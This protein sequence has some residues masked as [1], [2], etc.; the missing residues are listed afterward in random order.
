[1]SVVHVAVAVI[2]RDR[3]HFFDR[4]ILISC[5]ADDVHQGGLWEFP[6]GKVERDETVVEALARELQEELGIEIDKSSSSLEPLI[7]IHHDYGDKQVFL[8]VWRVSEFNCEPHGKEGQPVQWVPLSRLHAF[9]F[10]AANQPIL[11]ACQLPRRY[12]ITPSY[13][14]LSEAKTDI[15]RLIDEGAAMILLRQPQLDSG[16]Y[17]KWADEL[18]PL[19]HEH[20]VK[21]L[22]SGAPCLLKHHEFDGIQLPWLEA[23]KRL[24]ETETSR[25]FSKD[26]ILGVS[27]HSEEEIAQTE[28]L[29]AN[30]ATL[31]PVQTTQSHPEASP[32]GWQRFSDIVHHAKLPVYALG[33]MCADDYN[34][35]INAG[36]QGLSGISLWRA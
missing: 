34:Q 30:F 20:R 32:L 14:D 25:L 13:L 18:I 7:E 29:G 27:C 36:A 26:L 23:S 12:V 33:G 17:L 3:G 8:D 21:L 11:D 4:E 9:D 1:M 16:A 24:N 35:A 2:E 15:F 22:A 6:G 31:S 5:R 28:R 19:C 10:P